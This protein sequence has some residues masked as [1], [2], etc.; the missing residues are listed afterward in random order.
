[1]DKI[2]TNEGYTGRLSL[3][4][5]GLSYRQIGNATGTHPETV[6]RYLNGH[7]PSA[8]FLTQVCVQYGVSGEWLLSGRLP[9]RSDEVQMHVLKNADPEVVVGVV[10]E[11]V[12]ESLR[13][14]KQVGSFTQKKVHEQD[15][16]ELKLRSC[17]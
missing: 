3:V 14:M 10:S 15:T 12:I 1:M 7:A 11:M 6:R 8:A 2:N 17:V 9:M 16:S 4:L 5:D 13:T